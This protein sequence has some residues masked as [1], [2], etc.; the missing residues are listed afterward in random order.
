MF[1]W[2]L[3]QMAL[4]ANVIGTLSE[5]DNIDA[6]DSLDPSKRLLLHK[7][8]ILKV[9]RIIFEAASSWAESKN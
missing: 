4:W 5:V 8:C 9:L 1:H 6:I 2:N 7:S 3:W